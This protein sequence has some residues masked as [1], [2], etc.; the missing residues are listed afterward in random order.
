[1]PR[2]VL[3]RRGDL[4]I[5]VG[6]ADKKRVRVRRERDPGNLAKQVDLL[7]HAEARGHVVQVHKVG[8]LRGGEEASVGREAH[9]SHRAHVAHKTRERLPHAAHV[10]HRRRRVLVPG[11]QQVAARVPRRRE[12]EV[13]VARERRRRLAAAQVGQLRDDGVADD[14][15]ERAAGPHRRIVD[16]PGKGHLA[17][18]L[19]GAGAVRRS[20][21]GPKGWSVENVRSKCGV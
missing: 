13:A 17:D 20:E 21:R 8:R 7:L 16:R 12:R 2:P 19:E 3:R 9:R 18:L 6:D 11:R 4:H 14:R 1:M 5:G 15:G 10:P